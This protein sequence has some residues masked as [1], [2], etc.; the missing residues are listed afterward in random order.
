MAD[1]E[2]L[3]KMVNS[4]EQ[5]NEEKIPQKSNSQLLIEESFSTFKNLTNYAITA[6]GGIL[7]TYFFGA[8]AGLATWGSR[9]Y[10]T[11]MSNQLRDKPTSSGQLR[12]KSIE[13]TLMTPAV[14]GS[15]GLLKSAP[16]AFG[17]DQLAGSLFIGT[18]AFFALNP[19]L[20]AFRMATSYVTE[21]KTLKGIK[22]Y[23]K[24]NFMKRFKQRI[25]LNVIGSAAI[26]ITYAYSA[27]APYL[28]PFLAASR[29]FYDAFLEKGKVIYRRLAYPSTYLFNWINPFY[30]VGGYVS[31]LKRGYNGL[32]SVV[33]SLGNTV[34]NFFKT[35]QSSETQRQSPGGMQGL[36]QTT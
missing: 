6:A 30:I 1:N 26:G 31:L 32:L 14:V 34:Y 10:G 9:V 11:R 24:E 16:K 25:P 36:P 28:F 8:K 18:A 15:V 20:S 12:D 19:V 35:I 7:S 3:E 23:F 33:N 2:T 4:P 17:L 29:L 22:G 13:S 5:K 27:L 21:N